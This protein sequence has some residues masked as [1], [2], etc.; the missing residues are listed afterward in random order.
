MIEYYQITGDDSHQVII[1]SVLFHIVSIGSKV[2]PPQ[3]SNSLFAPLN[4]GIPV[5][6]PLRS[7]APYPLRSN[8]PF[9]P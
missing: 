1:C 5:I 9:A 2:I 7:N 3:G 8:D 6:S 4:G